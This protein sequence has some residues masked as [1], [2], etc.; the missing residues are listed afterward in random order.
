MK[1]LINK[2]EKKD[3]WHF[4]KILELY[5]WY[6]EVCTGID[7]VKPY[8]LTSGLYNDF[9]GFYD[10]V[11]TPHKNDCEKMKKELTDFAE[12]EGWKISIDVIDKKIRLWVYI[13]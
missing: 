8:S 4:C 10:V 12:S 3:N 2:P 13:Q 11:L 6:K 1:L 5:L 7:N 9:Y